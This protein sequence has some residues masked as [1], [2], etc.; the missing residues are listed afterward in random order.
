MK[1][2]PRDGRDSKGKNHKPAS[3]FLLREAA[4]W[5]SRRQIEKIEFNRIEE[6]R[7]GVYSIGK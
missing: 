2:L 1:T 5:W 7:L 4:I 3:L 6:W